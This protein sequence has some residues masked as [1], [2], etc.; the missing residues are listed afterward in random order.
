MYPFWSPD[1]KDIAYFAGGKLMRVSMAGGSPRTICDAP[2]GEGGA[3]AQTGDGDGVIV[4]APELAGPLKRVL[5]QG[6]VPTAATTLAKDEIG[7]SF[8]QVLPDGRRFLYLVRGNRP[9][10]YVQTL[11]GEDRTRVLDSIGR[12]AF[13]P[14]NLLLYLRDNTLLGQRLNLNTLQLVGEPV[15][16]AEGVRSGAANGR[17]AFSVSANGVLAYRGGGTLT[18]QVSAYTRDGKR[19]AVLVEAGEYGAITLSPDDSR[20]ILI[21]GQGTDRDL[22]MKDLSSGVLSRLTSAPE[23]DRDAVWSPDGRRI[24]YVGTEGNKD[25]YYQS[26][27]GSGRQTPIWNSVAPSLSLRDWTPDGRQLV[28]RGGGR[29]ALLPAPQENGALRAD[30]K[31]QVLVD[32]RYTVDQFRVSP[33]GKWVAYMSTESGQSQVNVATFPAFSDRRQITSA[34]SGA[35]QPLWRADG[36]ELFYLIREQPS[37]VVAV[38][39]KLDTTITLGPPRLLFRAALNSNPATHMYAATRD[40]QRFYVREAVGNQAST[41]ESLYV[42]TNWTSLLG[43]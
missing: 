5:A 23:G 43:R 26:V 24:A 35:S 6:G 39:V 19:E 21:K 17:N 38:D 18:F 25:V 20:L 31:P 9:A 32:E 27:I 42:V 11:G 1:S 41:V 3:W 40:G 16:I 22:W 29:V 30:A 33:D 13:S 8:P 14:P 2:S 28:L 12:A 37:S 7:H 34:T 15:S 36:K 4:F 10:I